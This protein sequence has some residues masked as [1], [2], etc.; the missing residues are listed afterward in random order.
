MKHFFIPLLVVVAGAFYPSLV[1]GQ[2][3]VSD[4]VNSAANNESLLSRIYASEVRVT[5]PANDHEVKGTFVMKNGED[6][7]V[8]GIQYEILLIDPLRNLP[9]NELVV[10]SPN[11]YDRVRSTEVIT[12][13]ANEKRTVSFSY[14]APNVPQGSYRI[15]IQIVTT[16]DRKLGWGDTTLTM[17]GTDAF[18]VVGAGNVDVDSID[19]V[20]KE[21]N[22][23]WPSLYGVNVGPAQRVTLHAYV[24]N[25]GTKAISG[26]VTI[27]T[28]RL[29]YAN[30]KPVVIKGFPVSVEPG[31]EKEIQ[32]PVLTQKTPGAYIVLVTLQDG[33]GNK[34]SGVGEYRYVVRGESASVA[35][36]QIQSIPAAAEGL[37]EVGFVLAGSADRATPVEGTM[38]IEITDANG[39]IGSINK[40]FSV[41][42]A[43]PTSGNAEI[44]ITRTVCGT[45]SITI[46]LNNKKGVEL[47]R[48]SVEASS[49][50]NPSCKEP[51]LS[52]ITR[53]MANGVIAIAVLAIV[54][55]LYRIER[56]KKKKR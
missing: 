13:K 34:I 6:A 7:T 49:F 29:L 56:K 32:I 36:A 12:M 42:P 11:V 52:F 31:V 43:L 51:L 38:Y 1:M 48:Y 28:K 16:N 5:S 47:D 3:T 25:A 40:E 54:G 8:G 10:D 50:A 55:A 18:L 46:I 30:E 24:K 9:L 21:Q 20:T 22:T 27:S 15:R 14:Q 4:I 26:T 37:A 41:P 23:T 53:P 19:P 17:G 39:V 45:P 33:S 2:T 35:S 44:T